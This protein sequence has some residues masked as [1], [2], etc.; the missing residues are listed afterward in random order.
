MIKI[1]IHSQNLA[2]CRYLQIWG[3]LYIINFVDSSPL[4]SLL[5]VSLLHLFKCKFNSKRIGIIVSDYILIGIIFY[6]NKK[7]YIYENIIAFLIYIK[8]LYL[9]NVNPIKL[10]SKYLKNDDK[11]YEKENYLNYMKRIWKLFIFNNNK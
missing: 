1:K 7:L 11:K 8:I 5:L 6:K 4:L 9:I 10:Y 2:Y 3:I